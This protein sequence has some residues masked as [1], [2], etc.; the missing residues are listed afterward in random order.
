MKHSLILEGE[1]IDEHTIHIEKALTGI[2]GKLK[3]VVEIPDQPGSE[4]IQDDFD[5]YF[6]NAQ[7]DMSG[8]KF[9]REEANER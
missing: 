3:I 4:A 7:V 5:E 8:F 2:T 1:L 6:M 9:S